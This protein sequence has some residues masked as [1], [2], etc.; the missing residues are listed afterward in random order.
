MTSVI[1]AIHNGL[2]VNRLFYESLKTYSAEAF[3][4]IVI[5]NASTD[6]SREFF[7]SVGAKVIENKENYSYPFC[8]NQGIK[9]ATGEWLAFLNN[10]IV[11][12]PEWDRRLRQVADFHG[13][14]VIT[15]CGIERL[16]S[17]AAT[18][19]IRRRW[20][21]IKNPLTKIFGTRLFSLKLMHKLMYGNWVRFCNE[22]FAQFGTQVT[23]GFVGNTVLMSRSAIDKVGMWDERIQA[24][25][26]DLYIRCKKRALEHGD[27]KPPHIALGIFNHHFI[28]LTVKAKPPA[29]ADRHKLIRLEEKYSPEDLKVFLADNV[30]T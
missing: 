26:F 2:A 15:P 29:F 14:E 28:R 18:Q 30:E 16:E 3:E 20:K 21:K 27:I 6:G 12:A 7:Q 17:A 4:L 25:D 10:D 9:E 23:E 13:L 5:D 24:A 1:T 8:Q 22:R 19:S 11:V